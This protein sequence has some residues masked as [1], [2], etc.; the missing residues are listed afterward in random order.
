[1]PIRILTIGHSYALAI[2]RSLIREIANDPEFEVTVA[3]PHFFHGDLR[4]I[5]MEPEPPGSRVNIVGLDAKWSR[6]IHVFHYRRSKLNK[7]TRQGGFDVV[8]AWEEPYIYAGFQI[9][10]SLKY[11]QS[12]FCFRTAQNYSKRYPP[13][14]N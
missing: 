3:A 8:H 11:S 9:A 10:E 7:L 13:P 5:T 6:F 4:P 12:R 2:N 14:F 1:M